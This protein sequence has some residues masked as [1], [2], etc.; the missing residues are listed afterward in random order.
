MTYQ[1]Q[2][3]KHANTGGRLSKLGQEIPCVSTPIDVP[4][5]EYLAS[6]H[7][8]EGLKAQAPL[9][10]VDNTNRPSVTRIPFRAI[11]NMIQAS[12]HAWW[13]GRPLLHLLT[14]KWTSGDWSWHQP[15]QDTLGKWLSR[16]SGGA[17]YIW[18]KEGNRVPHSHFLVHLKPGLTGADCW[19]VVIRAL[20]RLSGL[21]ALPK[22]TV[23]C[24]A[25][26]FFG[27]KFGHTKRR[28][29]YLCKGGG[30]EVRAF[31][32][33]DKDDHACV[34]G[35][36]AGVSETL[37]EAA[38]KRAGGCLPSGCRSVPETVK[39]VSWFTLMHEKAKTSANDA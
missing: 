9:I 1:P 3:Q 16:K 13:I 24:R 29:A 7:Q 15:V 31:L 25:P 39:F 35:K 11:E 23:Q 17:Y 21:S 14:I 26:C 12:A 4:A 28:T 2:E 22:G 32:G 36:Q 33:V 27:P 8:P 6:R 19:R 5:P 10:Y 20:K 30:A 34:P 38:R 37:G 18:V